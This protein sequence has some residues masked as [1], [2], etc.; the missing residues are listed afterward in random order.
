[1]AL[2]FCNTNSVFL[3]LIKI[4]PL[5]LFLKTCA[6]SNTPLRL[7]TGLLYHVLFWVTTKVLEI[8]SSNKHHNLQT[9]E[10]DLV[11]T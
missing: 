11:K 10:R 3:F 9:E 6:H 1:M 2:T 5:G 4:Y 7:Q 8:S